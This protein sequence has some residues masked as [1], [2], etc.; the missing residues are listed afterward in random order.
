MFLKNRFGVNYYLNIEK[1]KETN[2]DSLERIVTSIIPMARSVSVFEQ[3][4]VFALPLSH[5]EKF[6]S[7]FTELENRSQEM[8]V[9][10]F[11]VT[12]TSLEEVFLKLAAEED[13]HEHEAQIDI[14]NKEESKENTR[15]EF[16]QS[17]T[18]MRQI[19]ALSLTKYK[20]FF[21]NFS[22]VFCSLV[23]PIIMLFI[24][25]LLAYINKPTASTTTS[26]LLSPSIYG[27]K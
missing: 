13:S 25:C 14:K 8:G 6:S 9:L 5:V 27:G 21:R 26:L 4:V 20:Q 19:Q 15:I 17:P 12:L 3:E 22:A 1:T 16:H 7:L 18:M 11:G 24:G 2:V 23:M 10:S